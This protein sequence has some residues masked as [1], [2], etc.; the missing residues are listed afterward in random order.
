M[1]ERG[2]D[3]ST[4][5]AKKGKGSISYSR[6]SCKRAVSTDKKLPEEKKRAGV[7]KRTY[8]V[9]QS[10]FPWILPKPMSGAR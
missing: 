6:R 1:D 2:E 5:G 3:K 10:S 4:E 9:P 8:S 7:K